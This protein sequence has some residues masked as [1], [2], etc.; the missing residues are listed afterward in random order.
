MSG[1]TTDT[2]NRVTSDGT[3]TYTYDD[4]G[5]MIKKSKG[6]SAETWVYSYD[7]AG[8]MTSASKSATDGGTV[9]DSESYTFDAFGNRLQ[10]QSTSGSTTTTERFAY[11]GWDTAKGEVADLHIFRHRFVTDLVRSGVLPEFFSDSWERAGWRTV[12]AS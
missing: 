10:R 3:W 11:D 12:R 8:Q 5:Q 2:G 6:S 7:H 9:T 4:A 1:Y